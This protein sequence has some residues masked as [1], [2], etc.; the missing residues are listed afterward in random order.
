MN[1]EEKKSFMLPPFRPKW[2]IGIFRKSPVSLEIYKVYSS[3]ILQV[4][5]VSLQSI[6]LQNL[7]AIN[8][9]DFEISREK[10]DFLRTAIGHLG[11]KR[12]CIIY[13]N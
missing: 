9:I 8:L 7:T 11:V 10:G 12:G 4:I 2:P 3:Q 5:S 13:L 6:Y 1:S